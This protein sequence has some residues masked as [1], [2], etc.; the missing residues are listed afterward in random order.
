MFV[1]LKEK[2]LLKLSSNI[3]TPELLKTITY[4]V[5]YYAS[6]V[7]EDSLTVSCLQQDRK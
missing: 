7:T 5:R 3:I 1:G 4:R 2:I 6:G